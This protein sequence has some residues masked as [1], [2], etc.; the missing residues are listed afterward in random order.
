VPC[1]ADKSGIHPCHVGELPPH[2]AA[3]NSMAVRSMSLAVEAALTGD[4][5][6]LYWSV[7]Y[8]PLTA[9]ALSLQEIRDMVDELF[10]AEK[11]RMP[12]FRD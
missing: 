4:R 9:A 12:Q 3:L 8:D 1:F 6:L 5:D 10:E 7:A 11:G 2:L